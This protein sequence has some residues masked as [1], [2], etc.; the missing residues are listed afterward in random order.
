M[1]SRR[2]LSPPINCHSGNA[3]ALRLQVVQRLVDA[4]QRRHGDDAAFEK[5]V[6]EHH[7]PEM[8][9]VARVL[10][11]DQHPDVL[12]RA[13]DRARLELHRRLAQAVKA[14]LVGL[15]PNEDPVPQPGVDDKG[16][17]GGDLHGVVLKLVAAG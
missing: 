3:E 10:A 13:R 5:R 7:L 2:R 17:D 15:D 6:T 8:L 4:G 1:R 16:A 14:R 9:D 11:D 12:D